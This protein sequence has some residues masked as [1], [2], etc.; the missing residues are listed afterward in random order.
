[1]AT[2]D[3]KKSVAKKAR[4][5]ANAAVTD[6]KSVQQV[7][8]SIKKAPAA[9]ALSGDEGASLVRLP[10][11]Q[12]AGTAVPKTAFTQAELKQSVSEPSAPQVEIPNW[13]KAMI[14]RNA[15]YEEVLNRAE[16]QLRRAPSAEN[17]ILV[18][19]LTNEFGRPVKGRLDIRKLVTPQRVAPFIKAKEG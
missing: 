17:H 4:P 2:S 6:I 3:K 1:M 15:S 5:A 11:K 18:Q 16:D 7:A 12:G 8:D 9:A 14:E 10:T 19:A 13:V